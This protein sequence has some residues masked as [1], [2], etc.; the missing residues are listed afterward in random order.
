MYALTAHTYISVIAHFGAKSLD[1]VVIRHMYSASLRRTAPRM[2][3]TFSRVS[4]RADEIFAILE[5]RNALSGG[6]LSTR[7]RPG[8]EALVIRHRAKWPKTQVHELADVAE[9][10]IKRVWC[11]QT[12]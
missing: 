5:E 1:K 9:K 4:R 7:L 6:A 2:P 8:L 11:D 3:R 10:E 12:A